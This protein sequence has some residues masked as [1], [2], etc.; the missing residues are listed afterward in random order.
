MRIGKLTLFLVVALVAYQAACTMS[1]TAEAATPNASPSSQNAPQCPFHQHQKDSPNPPCPHQS[2]SATVI[3][4][5][6][7]HN[8][9]ASALMPA[10]S[11]A[12]LPIAAPLAVRNETLSAQFAS[13]PGLSSRSSSVLRI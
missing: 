11:A 5:L 10:V 4:P 9:G 3:S 8:P 13:P 7:A 12:T 6:P 2:I 1:C